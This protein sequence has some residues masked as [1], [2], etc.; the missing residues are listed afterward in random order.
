MSRAK[1][2]RKARMVKR[3][4]KA[5]R[6]YERAYEFA[7]ELAERARFRAE[8]NV[9]D[10]PDAAKTVLGYLADPIGSVVDAANKE[11]EKRKRTKA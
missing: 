6:R 1:R 3:R 11:L 7:T 4:E 8:L 5:I 2:V 9:S 10:L